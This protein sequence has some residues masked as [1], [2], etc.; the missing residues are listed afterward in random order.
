M[1]DMSLE[2]IKELTE[3]AIIRKTKEANRGFF[4]E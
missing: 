1:N 4:Y 2:K 3:K